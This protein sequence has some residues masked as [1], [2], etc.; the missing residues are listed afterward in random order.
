[1]ASTSRTVTP[2]S[3][4][5][6]CT[7]GTIAS[8]CARLAISG[9][10]PPNRSCSAIDV[11]SASDSSVWPRTSPIP[12]S[13]QDV[14]NPSTS[15]SVMPAHLPA[16]HHGV[17]PAGLVVAAP[18]ADLGEPASPVEPLG[19]LVVGPHLQ[20]H[21]PAADVGL[22]QQ[23]VQQ[24]RPDPLP[25]PRRGDADGGDVRLVGVGDQPGVTDHVVAVHGHQVV[26]GV[27]AAQLVAV[28]RLGPR[29][30]GEELLLHRQHGGEVVIRHVPQRDGHCDTALRAV[31]GTASGRRR[32]SGSSGAGGRSNRGAAARSSPAV[33]TSASVTSCPSRWA[34]RASPTTGSVTGASSG[35]STPGPAT[36]SPAASYTAQW[37]S[38]R[39]ASVTT[40]RAPSPIASSEQ[41]PYT[42]PTTSPSAAAVTTPT[43][44]PVN[45]PGPSP[46]TRAPRSRIR[47]PASAST[48]RMVGVSSSA[49]RLP[50]GSAR[51]AR[52]CTVRWAGRTTAPSTVTVV[53]SAR[54]TTRV[55]V[56]VSRARTS[57]TDNPRPRR[58]AARGPASR[59]AVGRAGGHVP[60]RP[61]SGVSRRPPRRSR[62]RTCRASA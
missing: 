54:P 35:R 58:P 14:S 11:A 13:S 49:C 26:P 25:L 16:H 52:T 18:A 34:N 22:G 53:T 27:A 57:T 47:T 21:D 48:S 6:L 12:V 20:Q 32:Y 15:G 36:R 17:G 24:L 40:E 1:I 61:A 41:T 4:S 23:G 43:R 44:R 46:T 30:G 33:V 8:R 60:A 55:G 37:T 56:A 28:H 59:A 62:R 19:E 50:E 31:G 2:A 45:G 9:T 3:D 51:S 39:R 10:T 7:V 5:A 38:L 29:V 42:G